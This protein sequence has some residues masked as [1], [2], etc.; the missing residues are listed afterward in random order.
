MYVSLDLCRILAFLMAASLV[1]RILRRRLRSR[2]YG[3]S[4]LLSRVASNCR[5]ISL[6]MAS[7]NLVSPTFSF[8]HLLSALATLDNL[9]C[10]H[11]I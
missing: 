8:R 1:L 6:S 5:R 4:A 10:S 2:S 9:V 11:F 3:E 7:Y